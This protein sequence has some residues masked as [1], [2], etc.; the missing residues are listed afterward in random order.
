MHE[1][2]HRRS[3]GCQDRRLLAA[4]ML[5]YVVSELTFDISSQQ[6]DSLNAH[7]SEKHE[8]RGNSL[9]RATIKISLVVVLFFPFQLQ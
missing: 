8:L 5:R 4:L 3:F 9:H 1:V 6:M 7:V 2:V